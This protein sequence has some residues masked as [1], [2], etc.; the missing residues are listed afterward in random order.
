[1]SRILKALVPAAALAGFAATAQA[2]II[3]IGSSLTF[4]GYNLPGAC[5]NT[6]CSDTVTF[7]TG[8]VSIAGGALTLTTQQV[9]DGPN[10]E[11]DVWTITTANGGPLAGNIASN[12]RIVMD[13]VLGSA[14]YFDQVV[15]QWTVGGTPVSPLSYFGICCAA[16]SNPSPVSGEAYYNSGFNAPLAAGTQTNWQQIYVN[17]Y[18][19]VTNGGIDPDTADGFTFALHFTLQ[20]PVPPA[21]PEPGTLALLGSGLVGLAGLTGVRLPRRRRQR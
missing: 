14:V 20:T 7:G 13:Y 21:V 9:A 5:A 10:A 1:M 15:N 8:P 6:T 2:S 3:P 4:G 17:P 19:Y 16:G 11:W 18:N 12:W